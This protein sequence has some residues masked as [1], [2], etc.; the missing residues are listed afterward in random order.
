MICFPNCKINLGLNITSKRTDGYHNIETVFYPVPLTDVLEV[1]KSE[2]NEFSTSGDT[3]AGK[4]EDNLC[5]AADA[6][7]K[8]RYN[9]GSVK[10]HLHKVIPSGA[11][12]GG[13]S[14]D[15]AFMIK[16]LDEEFKLGMTKIELHTMASE[17]GSD[18]A[19]FI[20]NKPVFAQGRG[21]EFEDHPLD[22]SGYHLMLVKP[23][24]GV[25]TAQAYSCVIPAPSKESLKNIRKD[26][27]HNWK[28]F[29]K[30]DFENS[31]FAKFPELSAIK[32]QLYD[33]GA[34]YASMSGS[35]SC[36]YGLFEKEINVALNFSGCFCRNLKL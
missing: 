5:L 9:I 34:L 33:M 12:L 36:M 8:K 28:N 32:Q 29:V 30:N 13:G 24:Y 21:N 35:G 15:A 31:V 25:P 27:I 7:V 14:S 6:A 22:L 3:I 20:E 26:N 11:G 18:C 17:L 10:I 23:A 2:K 19:F 16:L 4:P 1:V